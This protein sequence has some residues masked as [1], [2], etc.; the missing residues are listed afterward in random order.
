MEKRRR[1]TGTI[2]RMN[3]GTMRD[4]RAIANFLVRQ[5]TGGTL[6]AT[7]TAELADTLA[8]IPA[9]RK[10]LLRGYPTEGYFH[11]CALL[12]VSVDAGDDIP[13]IET[14][15]PRAV[16]TAPLPAAGTRL[17]D[18]DARTLA[19]LVWSHPVRVLAEALNCSDAAIHKR[20]RKFDVRTPPRGFWAKVQSG[21]L[22]HPQGTPAAA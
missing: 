12:G 6:A 19:R 18:L 21:Y 14:P 22:P 9:G 7:A 10:V 16:E 11:I 5:A 4:G 15:A 17:A 20:C 2:D 1:V 13:T 3:L 8:R